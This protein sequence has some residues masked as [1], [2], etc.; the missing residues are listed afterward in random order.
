MVGSALV[1]VDE[2]QH[3]ALRIGQAASG[4]DITEPIRQLAM[5]ILGIG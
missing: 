2:A 3:L 5:V 1:S 4:R